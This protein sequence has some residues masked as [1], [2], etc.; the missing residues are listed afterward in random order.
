ML[1]FT[2]QVPGIC[3]IWGE[4]HTRKN[5][6]TH[7]ANN[8]P[9]EEHRLRPITIHLL[10]LGARQRGESLDSVSKE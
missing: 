9:I 6:H 1:A 7:N 10:G 2:A 3:N 4:N 5:Y 8:I